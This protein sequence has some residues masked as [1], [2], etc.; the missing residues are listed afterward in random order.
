[1]RRGTNRSVLPTL[2]PALLALLVASLACGGSLPQV[3]PP[4]PEA[5]VTPKPV[6]SARSNPA[7]FGYVVTYEQM[8]FQVTGLIRPADDLVRQGNLF[9]RQAEAGSEYAFVQVAVT[10]L[11]GADETCALHEVEFGL[12]GSAGLDHEV[13]L[14]LAGVDGL[15]RGGDL[16]GGATNTGYLAFILGQEETD[17]ILIYEPLLGDAIYMSI[18][19]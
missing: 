11:R 17:L 18:E 4:D 6:G 1:M 3:Q 14:F 10:C 9:N 12:V 5:T 16:Y 13:V 8:T 7:P 19:P 15:L 2:L